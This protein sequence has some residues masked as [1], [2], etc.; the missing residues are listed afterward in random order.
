M[1]AVGC[2]AAP[3]P[4]VAFRFDDN[5]NVERWETLAGVFRK[6]NTRFSFSIIPMLG[7]EKNPEWCKKICQLESEGFEV[8]DHTPQHTTITVRLPQDDPRLKTLK[9]A[10][11]VDHI[12]GTKVC[13]KYSIGSSIF[14]KPFTVRIFDKNKITSE[15][16]LLRRMNLEIDGKHYYLK[17]SDKKDTFILFSI[18]DENNV[19]LPDG[20]KTVR[21]VIKENVVLADGAY[22]FLIQCSQE[23]FRKIGLKKMP[24]VWIQPGG[25]YPHLGIEKLSAA[26]RKY[27]YVS[28][29]C[30]Q[31]VST[32]GFGDPGIADRR[33]SMCWG[34]FNLAR[35]Q[36]QPQKTRIADAL[37]CRRTAIGSSHI[38]PALRGQLKEYVGM[39]DQLLGWLKENNIKVMTQSELADYLASA[40]IDPAENIMPSLA[41]DIDGNNRPDGYI[42]NKST[43]WQKADHAVALKGKGA[44]LKLNGLC[45]LP[46]GKVRFAMEIRGE[47]TGK[48]Y[49]Y[50]YDSLKKNIVTPI[51]NLNE[52]SADWKKVEYTLEIPAECASLNFWIVSA[53]ALQCSMR[54]PVLTAAAAK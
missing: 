36:L 5:H 26:L 34:D 45:G 1:L 28:A 27:N 31:N 30:Q 37:A 3:Q 23:G 17:S 20:E 19:N 14:S 2:V 48:V 7:D 47:F 10:S 29:S 21:R 40:K 8:M 13:L 50:L 54:N 52:K 33:F 15:S 42:L 53:Q 25:Y 9:D 16:K 41:N 39:Y 12:N 18:W 49:F 51:W 32:K 11:F 44:L 43:Q 6:H 38:T 4:A 24:K 46:R 35:L 22:D